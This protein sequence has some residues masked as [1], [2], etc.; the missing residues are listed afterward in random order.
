[1]E[2]LSFSTVTRVGV[3]ARRILALHEIFVAGLDDKGCTL[4]AEKVDIV[5]FGV[6]R[7]GGAVGHLRRD[8]R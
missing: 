7:R 2:L 3:E 5:H 6:V 8:G 1:M 4:S